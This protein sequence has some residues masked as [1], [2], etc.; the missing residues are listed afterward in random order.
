M[1]GILS[2]ISLLNRASDKPTRNKPSNMQQIERKPQIRSSSARAP[3]K[4]SLKGILVQNLNK[5]LKGIG[6][7][8][9]SLTD[10]SVFDMK[11]C[12]GSD[13]KYR[14]QCKCPICEKQYAMNYKTS[15][16][17]VSIKK[18]L[19]EHV[20]EIRKRAK[21]ITGCAQTTTETYANA[22]PESFPFIGTSFSFANIVL[23]TPHRAN[24][25]IKW[26]SVKRIRIEI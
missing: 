6:V 18:H 7:E 17:T 24:I 15:W 22:E 21:I 25:R 9:I 19:K 4:D 8:N 16:N 3:N 20:D 13:M 5:Y 10:E 1:L 2:Q 23:H 14:C 11:R 12:S 26:K